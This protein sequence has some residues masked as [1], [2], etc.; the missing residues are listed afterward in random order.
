M[1]VRSTFVSKI[2]SGVRLCTRWRCPSTPVLSYR[3]SDCLLCA[4]S[5]FSSHSSGLFQKILVNASC[6]ETGYLSTNFQLCRVGGKSVDRVTVEECIS[7][8]SLP[9]I[10]GPDPNA[11]RFG[12]VGGLGAAE[13]VHLVDFPRLNWSI[14]VC[15]V[16]GLIL[17][18]R[19][20]MKA[21]WSMRL[22][23]PRID[24]TCYAF[25]AVRRGQPSERRGR[26]SL[27]GLAS[28]STQHGHMD[29]AAR[30]T[31]HR[32]C[33]FDGAQNAGFLV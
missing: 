12:E 14:F 10:T 23:T 30:C 13:I 4:C 20:P 21:N 11:K 16:K 28:V 9:T 19:R 1:Q 32:K 25:L 7:S 3:A 26:C 22:L 5:L 15:G 29:F 31:C 8:T 2:S 18:R 6:L 24:R 33:G 17:L 27:N